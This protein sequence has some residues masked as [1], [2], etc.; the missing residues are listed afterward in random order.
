VTVARFH[1]GDF[2]KF[3]STRDKAVAADDITVA[4]VVLV[5][6]NEGIVSAWLPVPD[7]SA[8]PHRSLEQCVQCH[9]ARQY[10]DHSWPHA[11]SQPAVGDYAENQVSPNWPI[12][13]LADKRTAKQ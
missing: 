9:N 3:L 5:G 4:A 8:T 13:L 7:C 10:G 1:V 12:F 6:L 2:G 11:C